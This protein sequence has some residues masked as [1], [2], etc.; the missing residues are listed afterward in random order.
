MNG[1]TLHFEMGDKPN[2][3][4]GLALEDKPFSLSKSEQ[5]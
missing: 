1:G 5:L 2:K 4:R 3:T